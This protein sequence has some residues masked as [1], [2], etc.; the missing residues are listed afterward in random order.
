MLIRDDRRA[1]TKA[2]VMERTSIKSM[3]LVNADQTRSTLSG[4]GL[5]DDGGR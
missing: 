5:D 2:A 3:F 4:T 1:G